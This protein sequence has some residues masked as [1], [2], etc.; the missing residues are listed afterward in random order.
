VSAKDPSAT[1]GAVRRALTDKLAAAAEASTPT[2]KQ[3]RRN[4]AYDRLLERPIDD[5]WIGGVES[6]CRH[7]MAVAR[8]RCSGGAPCHG[9]GQ[10]RW[11]PHNSESMAVG[12]ATK[13]VTI[14]LE[15]VDAAHVERVLAA[16]SDRPT[17]T[18]PIVPARMR[19]P[20]AT[21]GK[22]PRARTADLP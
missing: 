6:A 20:S 17:Q 1:P 12:M 18:Q 3:L 22:P 8:S 2:L 19:H 7:S 11:R 9:T 10:I 15:S 13:K 16:A 21:L 14:T 5:D 4:V